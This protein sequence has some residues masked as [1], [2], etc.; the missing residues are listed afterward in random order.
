MIRVLVVTLTLQERVRLPQTFSV[1]STTV[2]PSALAGAP[3]RSPAGR[4]SAPR[5]HCTL[6]GDG[7]APAKLEVCRI[8]R[9]SMVAQAPCGARAPHNDGGQLVRRYPSPRGNLLVHSRVLW[10]EPTLPTLIHSSPPSVPP[11][12]GKRGQQSYP[13][14]ESC[15][16]Y[17]PLRPVS[18]SSLRGT[19]RLP[20]SGGPA[21]TLAIAPPP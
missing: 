9:A 8:H 15:Q 12:P 11:M 18:P 14:R 2:H 3:Q 7:R 20:R 10:P 17:R 1:S 5:A 6:P 19:R 13:P 21:R 16:R 4:L